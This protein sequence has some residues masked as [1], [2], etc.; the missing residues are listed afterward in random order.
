MGEGR[1]VWV[2]EVKGLGHTDWK[3]QS[4]HRDVKYSI[5]NIV[6]NIL[7]AVCDVRWALEILGR[8]L[9]KVYDCLPQCFIHETN[10]KNIE[11]KL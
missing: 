11:C 6:H 5:G 7:I 3:L 1:E 2:K 4:S 9:C 10:T 8:P